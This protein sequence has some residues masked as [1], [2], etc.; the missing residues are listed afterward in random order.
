MSRR[1]AI[2][3]DGLIGRS[4]RMAWLARVPEAEVV[5]L[6]RGHD[7]SGLASAGIVVLSAPVDAILD[8]MPRLSAL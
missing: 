2:V 3:G 7:L 5:S 6:D 8:L 4:I 1:L